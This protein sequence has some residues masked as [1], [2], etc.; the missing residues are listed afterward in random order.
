M[1]IKTPSILIVIIVS[2]LASFLT[3][4][5]YNS[6]KNVTSASSSNSVY[7]RVME[8]KTLRC[9]YASYPPTAIYKDPQTGEIKG[10][11]V[12]IAE[13]MA[14]G[15]GLKLVW[16][17]E[18]GWSSFVEG[19]ESD[20]FDAFCAPLWINTERGMRVSFTI[21]IAYSAL[22]LYTRKDDFRFDNDVNILNSDQYTLATLDGEMSQV[23]ARRFF[24][25]AK[26]ESLPQLSEMSQLLL[27]VSGKKADGV[28]LEPGLAKAFALKNPNQIRQSTREPFSIFPISLGAIKIGEDKLQNAMNSALTEMLNQGVIDQIISKTGPDRSIYMPVRKPYEIVTPTEL[29]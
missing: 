16:A 20:R 25:K 10:I 26:Q 24:P 21:P 7:D 14:K 4:Y 22:H 19:L 18:T 29:P 8:T 5:F 11:F 15:M 28:F 23:V 13:E 12:E 2:I 6:S 9:G 1:Y 27:S 3:G 17:E